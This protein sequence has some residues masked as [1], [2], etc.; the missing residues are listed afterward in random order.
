M[1]SVIARV[2]HH[3]DGKTLQQHV[4]V[5]TQRDTS[6]YTDEWQSD[7][8][9]KHNHPTVYHGQ[10]EGT[11]DGDGIREVHTNTS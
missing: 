3:T 11:C 7:N 9:L 8:R 2:R 4:H 1:E 6:C 5:A 10:K